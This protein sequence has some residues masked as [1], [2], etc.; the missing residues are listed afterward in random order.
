[1]EQSAFVS[2]RDY[3]G[4]PGFG[5]A[6]RQDVA[7]LRKALT[8]GQDVNDPGVSAGQGF[9]L[10]IESLER[11]LKVV[12]YRL[13]DVRLWKNI[14]KLPA[15]NTVEEYSRLRSYGNNPSSAF[16]AE[17]D[18]PESSDSTYSREYTVIKFM[19]TTRKVSHVMTLTRSAHGPPIAQET[20][21][22]TAELLRAVEQSL[23]FGDSTLVDVQWD[24]LKPLITAGAPSTNI[25]DMR[26][27]PLTEDAL[28]D[29][30]LTVKTTPNYG[31]PTDLYCADGA[32]SDLAKSFYPAERLPLTPAG[33]TDG[34]VGVQIRGF[35]SMVGPIMF[36]PDVFIEFGGAVPSAAEGDAS[37]RPGLPTEDVAPAAG[38]G[39]AANLF[40]AADAGDYSYSIVAINRYGKAAALATTGPVT[41]A[42]TQK[43]TMSIGNGSPVASA[44]EIYR[45]AKDGATTTERLMMTVAWSADPTVI[46]DENLYLPGTSTAFMIQQNLDFFSF[47]QLCPFVKIPLATVDTSARWMQLLYGAPTVYAPAKAAI[48]INV[49]RAA[50]SVGGGGA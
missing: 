27:A 44:Y 18:L 25:I 5:S 20:V 32:Y 35:H 23:F 30:A 17:G 1:M 40:G 42:A 6:T 8:A 41:V 45:S 28:N 24:G 2:W 15:Y 47:K 29:G 46:T 7:E 39:S 9:P 19:G 43:V 16:I 33:F 4:L 36:N 22:G 13:D 31:R 12:T 37:K 38:A 3:E 21:N 10:R 48:Y 50:G 49:G 14:T 26:G 11:T 34:M